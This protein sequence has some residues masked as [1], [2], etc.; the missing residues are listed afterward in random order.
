MENV[1]KQLSISEIRSVKLIDRYKGKSTEAGKVNLTFRII[2]QSET[3]TLLSEEVDA[4]CAKIVTEFA[5]SFDA[6]LR[7]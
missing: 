7:K 5:K 4:L 2:F 1:F 6:E 3:R